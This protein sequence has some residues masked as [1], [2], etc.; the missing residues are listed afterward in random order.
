M[1]KQRR[2]QSH[3]NIHTLAANTLKHRDTDSETDDNE[4]EGEGTK[5]N[6]DEGEVAN[7]EDSG[8]EGP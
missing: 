1:K 3:E 8:K 2:K 4:T 7:A 5:E 6:E